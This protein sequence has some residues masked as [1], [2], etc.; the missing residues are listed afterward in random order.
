LLMALSGYAASRRES[1]V[2]YQNLSS[3]LP[4]H[5]ARWIATQQPIGELDARHEKVLVLHADLR[6]F[7]AWCNHLPAEQAGAVL[8]AFY[9]F[10][11][12]I[13][14]K[15]GGDV[16]EYVGDAVTAVWRGDQ[17]DKRALQAANEMISQGEELLGNQ[18]TRDEV[19]PLA[20]G[21]G[22]EYGDVL[23][24][25]FGPSQRRTYTVI[26]EGVTKAMQLQNLTSDIGVPILIGETAATQWLAE[27]YQGRIHL[28]SLGEFLLQDANKPMIIYT[29]AETA[30]GTN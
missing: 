1:D 22:I 5:A 8:H 18:T 7:S 28:E 9:T 3:Y 20:I 4:L 13:I 10:T 16:E 17:A 27:D 11:G 6:N 25:A 14:Q 2:L 29:P 21:I 15:M 24:G 19:P 30:D 12:G 23:A 26:G